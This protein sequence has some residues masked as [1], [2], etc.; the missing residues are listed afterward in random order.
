VLEE[1]L[2]VDKAV[3]GSLVVDKAVGMNTEKVVEDMVVE[4]STEAVVGSLVEDTVVV[5]MAVG[6]STEKVA[7]DVVVGVST[8][9]VEDIFAVV[10]LVEGILVVGAGVVGLGS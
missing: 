4:V 7:G 9:K 1:K 6:V 2:V 8:E 10:G 3:V 5:G